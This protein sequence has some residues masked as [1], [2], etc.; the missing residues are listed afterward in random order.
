MMLKDLDNLEGVFVRELPPFFENY[1]LEF[2]N[3]D[4]IAEL[5]DFWGFLYKGEA[6]VDN[7]QVLDYMKKRKERNNDRAKRY[8]LQQGRIKLRQKELQELRVKRIG[9]MSS[10]VKWVAA[11]LYRTGHCEVVV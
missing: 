1:Y 9:A 11:I 8:L 7:R 10:N 6:K 4:D 5:I 2:R 3:F